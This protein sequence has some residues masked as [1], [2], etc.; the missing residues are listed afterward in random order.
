MTRLAPAIAAAALSMLLGGCAQP[1]TGAPQGSA[2]AG[3]SILAKSKPANGAT[4][5]GPVNQAE[6]W[7]NPRA[8]LSEVTVTGPDGMMP[9]MVTAVG[10]V[11]YYSLP[12]SGLGRGSY[13]VTWKAAAS[14]TAYQGSFQFEVR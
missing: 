13:T 3:Q 8:R 5:A 7:F 6:L 14:G 10:E 11:G 1:D 9:M 12:L 4:V 2:V